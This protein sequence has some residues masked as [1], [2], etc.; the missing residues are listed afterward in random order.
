MRVASLQKRNQHTH[1][2]KIAKPKSIF[3]GEIINIKGVIMKKTL[4]IVAIMLIIAALATVLV[5]CNNAGDVNAYA[6]PDDLAV[7]VDIIGADGV[8]QGTIT[9]DVLVADLQTTVTMNSVNSY[10]TESSEI[11]VAYNLAD[12]LASMDID[13]GSFATV[14]L[15]DNT[16]PADIYSKGYDMTSFADTYLTI[17][18]E[19][20]GAFVADE[21]SLR[22][23]RDKNSTSKKDIF[24]SIDSI[25]VG[26]AA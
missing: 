12:V 14:Q 7:S 13:L 9:E 26:L 23:I 19:E 17:G 2:V 5:A 4:K 6:I 15:T 22:V 1:K 21:D 16:D 8:I 25:A 20:D 18:F 10:G 24:K 3:L 11:Y